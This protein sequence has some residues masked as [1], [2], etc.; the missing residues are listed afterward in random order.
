PA[1]YDGRQAQYESQTV[2]CRG[3]MCRMEANRPHARG[4]PPGQI[5]ISQVS[6]G[7][8]YTGSG[9][10]SI[11]TR[12]TGRSSTDSTSFIDGSSSLY[13]LSMDVMTILLP[14]LKYASRAWYASNCSVLSP[15]SPLNW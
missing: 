7:L 12:Q 2:P 3:S 5:I 13:P 14:S 10:P 15:E 6:C 8:I 9:M 11:L 4:L 1:S